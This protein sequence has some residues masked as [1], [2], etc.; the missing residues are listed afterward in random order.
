MLR[1]VLHD[2]PI[3]T[4]IHP[5]PYVDPQVDGWSAAMFKHATYNWDGMRDKLHLYICLKV[6]LIDAR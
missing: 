2:I 3:Y 4:F 6:Q 1:C 5:Q